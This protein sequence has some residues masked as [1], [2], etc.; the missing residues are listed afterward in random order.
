MQY[1]KHVIWKFSQHKKGDCQCGCHRQKEENKISYR[2]V[3]SENSA[4][5]NLSKT[6][7][8]FGILIY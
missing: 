1:A 8:I 7:S 6:L 4:E 5:Y 2:L 3:D